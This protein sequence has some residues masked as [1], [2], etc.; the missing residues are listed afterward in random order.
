MRLGKAKNERGWG[1]VGSGQSQW[2]DLKSDSRWFQEMMW[3][4]EGM[5]KSVSS[6]TRSRE[7]AQPYGE[8][9]TQCR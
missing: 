9:M 4:A 6:E 2:K 3:P 7:E 1:K 8:G 5:E